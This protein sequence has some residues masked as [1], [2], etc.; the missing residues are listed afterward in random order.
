[1]KDARICATP[2]ETVLKSFL[3]FLALGFFC[4]T[5][6]ISSCFYPAARSPYP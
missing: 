5:Y 6:F 1:L 3:L 2:L 4:S